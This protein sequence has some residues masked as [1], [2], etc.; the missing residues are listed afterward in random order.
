MKVV[1]LMT[2]EL[3][4]DDDS[5]VLAMLS[6]GGNDMASEMV[7]DYEVVV[8]TEENAD[9][10]ADELENCGFQSHVFFDNGPAGEDE[11]ATQSWKCVCSKS[12]IP[13]HADIQ[14]V[15]ASVDQIA[16]KLNGRYEAWGTFGNAQQS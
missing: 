16:R 6:E 5:A 2:E 1:E 14:Q 12:M 11:N 13:T 9:L 8:D 10:I 4:A 7:I 15:K 3:P